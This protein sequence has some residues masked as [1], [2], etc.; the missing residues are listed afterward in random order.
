MCRLKQTPQSLQLRTQS[1]SVNVELMSAWSQSTLHTYTHTHTLSLS[2]SLSLSLCHMNTGRHSGATTRAQLT[3]AKKKSCGRAG[4]L[5]AAFFVAP[6]RPSAFVWTVGNPRP[7]IE[8]SSWLR[9][10]VTN[11]TGVLWLGS[12]R[13]AYYAFDDALQSF[14]ADVSAQVPLLHICVYVCMYV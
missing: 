8:P 10:A 13:P 1:H 4:H 12:Q 7:V 9:V 14:E 6:P 5:T 3:P 2:L 11:V